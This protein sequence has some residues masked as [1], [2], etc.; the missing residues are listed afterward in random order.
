MTIQGMELL[1]RRKVFQGLARS[2][3]RQLL[4]EASK[5]VTDDTG[6]FGRV[7]KRFMKDL[8]GK[9]NLVTR[10]RHLLSIPPCVL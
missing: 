8:G 1:I 10:K 3:V 2:Q 4:E 6:F 5:P 9:V 7:A